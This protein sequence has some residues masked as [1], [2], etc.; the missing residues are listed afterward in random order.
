MDLGKLKKM[1]DT[2]ENVVDLQ[3]KITFLTT[4]LTIRDDEIKQVTFFL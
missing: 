1:I 2:Q 4:Q 3:N